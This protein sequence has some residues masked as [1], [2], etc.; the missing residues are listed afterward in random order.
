MILMIKAYQRV[1]S[2]LLGSRCRYYPTCSSYAIES[3]ESFGVIKG[4][5]MSLKRIGRCHPLAEGGYDPVPLF[6]DEKRSHKTCHHTCHH[7]SQIEY[8]SDHK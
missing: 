6:S 2:P 5:W 8:R 3:I 7:E 1:L 4:F